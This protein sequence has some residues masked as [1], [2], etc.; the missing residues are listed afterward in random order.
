MT[1][2]DITYNSVWEQVDFGFLYTN[3]IV[4]NFFE[5]VSAGTKFA[6]SK[7]E[8]AC[9]YYCVNLLLY[10]LLLLYSKGV[11]E[12]ITLYIKLDLQAVLPMFRNNNL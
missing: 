1:S 6:N 9:V 2:Y 8:Y 12:N 5:K 7:K 11:D 4:I 3:I 10:K